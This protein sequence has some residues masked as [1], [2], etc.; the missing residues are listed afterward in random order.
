MTKFE[1]WLDR[2]N[3]ERKEYWETNFSYKPYEPLKSEKGNKYIKIVD[4]TT[5]WAFVSMIDGELKGSPLKKGDL[6]K[7]ASWRTPA[8]HSRGNIFEGTDMWE[9]YGPKYL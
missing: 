2:V 5:V 4:G 1:I 9:F 6:L 3:Q 7:P 8:K